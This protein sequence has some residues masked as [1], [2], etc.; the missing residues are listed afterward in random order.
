MIDPFSGRLWVGSGSTVMRFTPDL[1]S[2]ITQAGFNAQNRFGLTINGPSGEI[3]DIRS[4]ADLLNWDTI[5]RTDTMSSTGV[6]NWTAPSKPPG[7][8]RFYRL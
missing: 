8:K 4:S 5:E 3:Y 2:R 1:T 7:P 6:M